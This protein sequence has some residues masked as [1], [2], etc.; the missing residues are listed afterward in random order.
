VRLP[1]GR[2]EGGAFDH[3]YQAAERAS[4]GIGLGG[5]ATSGKKR[6]ANPPHPINRQQ[7]KRCGHSPREKGREGGEVVMREGLKFIPEEN[8]SLARGEKVSET[9]F[10][11][12]EKKRRLNFP[13]NFQVRFFFRRSRSAPRR[14]GRGTRERKREDY[15]EKRGTKNPWIL[16][17][18]LKPSINVFPVMKGGKSR[19]AL[20]EEKKRFAPGRG[21]GNKTSSAVIERKTRRAHSTS[22]HA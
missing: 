6:M 14:R 16:A 7:G 5:E 21:A 10:I 4:A 2:G 11:R 1:N 17:A 15:R 13:V 8:G 22:G 12:G 18:T 19:V 20:K 3:I 9:C